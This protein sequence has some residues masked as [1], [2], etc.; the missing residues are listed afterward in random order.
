MH[1]ETDQ[2][3]I[4]ELLEYDGTLRGKQAVRLVNPMNEIGNDYSGL[5]GN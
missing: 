4:I 2:S 3:V 5:S 1:E